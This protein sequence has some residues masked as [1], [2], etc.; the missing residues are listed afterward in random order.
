MLFFYKM[1]YDFSRFIGSCNLY[2]LVYLK[3]ENDID[4]NNLFFKELT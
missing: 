4:V 1:K 2:P 3:Y